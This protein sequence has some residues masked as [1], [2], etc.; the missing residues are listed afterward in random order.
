MNIIIFFKKMLLIATVNHSYVKA[1]FVFH[2]F[3][4]ISLHDRYSG[5]HINF[6]LCRRLALD[7]HGPKSKLT[8][9]P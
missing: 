6:Q 2:G 1:Y 3:N 8:T 7:L 4:V 9:A 5:Y